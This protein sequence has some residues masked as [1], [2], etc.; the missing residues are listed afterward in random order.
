MKLGADPNIQDENGDTAL[1]MF[2]CYDNAMA[3]MLEK[4]GANA[5]IPNKQGFTPRMLR[6]ISEGTTG[7]K[8][9]VN[10]ALGNYEGT[11]K[12]SLMVFYLLFLA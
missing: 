1:H 6:Q 2:V 9:I 3:T 5:E 10:F 8:S 11:E 4:N 7:G 12:I